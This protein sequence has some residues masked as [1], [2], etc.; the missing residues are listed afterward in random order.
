MN[1]NLFISLEK[2]ENEFIVKY[3]S[4]IYFEAL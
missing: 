4:E 3:N 1:N 2:M